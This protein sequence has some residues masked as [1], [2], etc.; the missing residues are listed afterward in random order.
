M[1]TF[2][3]H[4]TGVLYRM[5]SGKLVP[6]KVE[7]LDA[8]VPPSHVP[9]LANAAYQTRFAAFAKQI[10]EDANRIFQVPFKIDDA[11]ISGFS[12]DGFMDGSYT[13]FLVRSDRAGQLSLDGKQIV[14]FS[15][16]DY[17]FELRAYDS[18]DFFE[19]NNEASL[20]SHAMAELTRISQKV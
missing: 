12:G 20:R 1:S 10:L 16:A 19:F 11:R 17:R 6:S 5:N 9:K 13:L 14:S 7:Y 8:D 4:R 15:D 3:D 2:Y 18:I